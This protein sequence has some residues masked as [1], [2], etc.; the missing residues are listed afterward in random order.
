MATPL[1]RRSHSLN[2]DGVLRPWFHFRQDVLTGQLNASLGKACEVRRLLLQVDVLVPHIVLDEQEVL[3]VLDDLDLLKLLLLV[4]LVV[5]DE[6]LPLGFGLW[7]LIHKTD[8]V[9][10]PDVVPP[11]ALCRAFLL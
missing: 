3:D 10:L 9:D 11:K 8:L 6:A 1:D 2:N 5:L 4:C 7:L